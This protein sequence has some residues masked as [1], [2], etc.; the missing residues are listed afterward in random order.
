MKN[1]ELMAVVR[2]SSPMHKSVCHTPL[3]PLGLI[4]FISCLPPFASEGET[5][6]ASLTLLSARI[7][8]WCRII[9]QWNVYFIFYF[10]VPC[11]QKITGLN[12][13]HSGLANS[14]LGN[15]DIV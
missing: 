7:T 11:T 10:F 4:F 9:C 5:N 6:C 15:V 13:Q 8:Q 3:L 1:E 12:K 2:W 14:V